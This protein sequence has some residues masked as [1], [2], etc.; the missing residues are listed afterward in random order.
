MHMR[1]ACHHREEEMVGIGSSLHSSC[2]QTR[3]VQLKTNKQVNWK[4]GELAEKPEHSAG[5]SY[6]D[7]LYG[8][9]TE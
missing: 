3:N 6:K 4:Q 8:W 1:I 2:H 7:E 9:N 5:F